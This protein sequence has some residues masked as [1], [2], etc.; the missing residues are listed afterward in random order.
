MGQIARCT[1]Y[2]HGPSPG[3]PWGGCNIYQLEIQYNDLLINTLLEGNLD[4]IV[5]F[6]NTSGQ[7]LPIAAGYSSSGT[8]AIVQNAVGQKR[9]SI[10]DYIELD[11]RLNNSISYS[12][13]IRFDLFIQNE[14]DPYYGRRSGTITC[15]QIYNCP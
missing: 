1:H 13:P 2:Y 10:F 4:Y 6:R 15:Q 7:P 14:S 11:L 12:N 9:F 5:E 3:D 8:S